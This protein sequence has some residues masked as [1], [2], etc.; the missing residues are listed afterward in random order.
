M[1][2]RKSHTEVYKNINERLIE[3]NASLI[4]PFVYKNN[5]SKLKLK[6]NIDGYIREV[7][8]YYFINFKGR[9]PRCVGQVL[10]QEEAINNINEKLKKINASLIEPF[11]YKNNNSL[12]KIKCNIDGH[13]RNL[14]YHRFVHNNNGCPKCSKKILYEKEISNN[15]NNRLEKINASL[16]EP[17]IHKNNKSKLKL[18]CNID[19]HE[20]DSKYS[21]F[22]NSNKG[23]AKCAG[24]LK[25]SQK[26]SEQ[27]VLEQ[28]II[29]NYT[30]NKPFVYKNTR[31]LTLEIKCMECNS[32]WNVKMNNFISR[33]SGCPKC[34]KSKGENEIENILKEKNIFYITEKIFEDCK[35]IGFLKFDFYLPK[36]NT[37]IEFDGIQHFKSLN[38][39]GG[40]EKLKETQKRDKIKNQYCIENN[41]DLI[42]IP[43]Y[44][45][46]NIKDIL[47]NIV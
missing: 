30:L 2:I 14:T 36:I 34:N 43:Y 11:V 28:C 41:I 18:K 38:F 42:R 17:Y 47:S 37:C 35:D 23:C 26:E 22:V 13:E 4:E 32:I 29:M 10:Y 33:K 45:F 25:L 8:Y 20:W 40:E 44:K 7:S 3:I 21:N 24:V 15:I 12:L 46:D 16:R 39:F 1:T 6:C 19:G 27:K 31:T 5:K 9:C